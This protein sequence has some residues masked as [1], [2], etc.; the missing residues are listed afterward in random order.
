M[1]SSIRYG[2]NSAPAVFEEKW[3]DKIR[4]I[5]PNMPILTDDLWGFALRKWINPG[6]QGNEYSNKH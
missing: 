6:V 3:I 1:I 4:A 2:K 5:D